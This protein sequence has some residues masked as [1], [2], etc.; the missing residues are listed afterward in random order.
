MTE[1]TADTTRL[2]RA[3]TDGDPEALKELTPRVYR[4]LRRM[5]A[6]FLRSERPGYTLE[7]VELVHEV[8]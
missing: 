8:Y 1:S 7:S 4:E 5:A 6:H 3:W 2:L